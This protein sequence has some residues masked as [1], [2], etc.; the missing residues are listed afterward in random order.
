MLETVY[1]G[2][3]EKMNLKNLSNDELHQNARA[4]AEKERLTTIEVLWH[5]R[6][7]EKRML[8]AEMGYQDLKTYCVKELKYSEASAWRRI[9]SMRMLAELPEVEEKIERGE[10]NLTQVSMARSF[11]REV[12]ATKVEK[13]EL[14]KNLAGKSTRESERILAESRPKNL[15]EM[16][17]PQ[18]QEKPLRGERVQ[19]TLIL[20]PEMLQDLEELERLSGRPQN[21]LELFRDL[22]K[23]RLERIKSKKCRAQPAPSA[24]NKSRAIPSAMRAKIKA[25]DDHRCQ[26]SDPRSGRKCGA[27][28]FLQVEHKTPFALGGK[29]SE[30]NLELL[31][32]NHNRLR[33]MQKFGREKI[34]RCSAPKE[35]QKN[36]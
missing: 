26:Y 14:L 19:L 32:T 16:A 34:E 2:G 36:L 23:E 3:K 13:Q 30:E 17:K 1:A 33:A 7:I 20:D 12:R 29:H 10:L 9:S 27:R 35:F 6:E 18:V 15:A 5:L 25:R 28:L 8:Y 4:L 11:F 24:A 21:K 31:C 22:V